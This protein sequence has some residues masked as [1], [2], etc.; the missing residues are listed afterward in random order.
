VIQSSGGTE[1]CCGLPDREHQAANRI[2]SAAASQT[3]QKTPFSTFGDTSPR[4]LLGRHTERFGQLLDQCV[5][6]R[7]ARRRLGRDLPA[8]RCEPADTDTTLFLLR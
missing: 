3:S 7:L 8:Y 5:V 4:T 6:I 2:L 1:N